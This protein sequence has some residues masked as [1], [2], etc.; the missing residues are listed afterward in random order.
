[1]LDQQR[2]IEGLAQTPQ[3]IVDVLAAWR[4]LLAMCDAKKLKFTLHAPHVPFASI[5]QIM[6]YCGLSVLSELLEGGQD[7]AVRRNLL[8]EMCGRASKYWASRDGTSPSLGNPP[9]GSIHHLA[10][11]RHRMAGYCSR[12]ASRVVNK[13]V[14]AQDIIS[15]AAFSVLQRK[16][17]TSDPDAG[18]QTSTW[19]SAI[20]HDVF[21][22]TLA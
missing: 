8:A 17:N 13:F 10:V 20:L 21:G 12:R 11:D 1:M 16:G 7:V 18:T 22:I 14:E 5:K 2:I 19:A 4:L 15:Q 9:L 6:S 3:D